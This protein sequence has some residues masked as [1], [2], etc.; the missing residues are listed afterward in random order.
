MILVSHTREYQQEARDA[1]LRDALSGRLSEAQIDA[2]VARINAV[3]QRFAFSGKTSTRDIRHPAHLI[4]VREAA[5]AAISTVRAAIDTLPLE[6]DDTRTIGLVEF[7]AGRDSD[8]EDHGN[9]SHLAARLRQTAPKVQV[10][11]L[12]ANQPSEALAD[13]ALLL[14]ERCDLLIVATRNA[15]LNPAQFDVVQQLLFH[16]NRS[17]LICLRN[18][19]D[20]SVLNGA[21]TILCT[22][23]DST[24]SLDAVV[25]VLMGY[26]IPTA[27]VPVPVPLDI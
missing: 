6:S 15:H 24:P 14:N 20:A 3:K 9:Q 27:R 26:L 8:A 17:I 12:N 19:F 2:A 22:C 13:E 18:P 7:A 23:S 16:A 5:R 11:V 25:E 4:V 21:D 10:V 1:L